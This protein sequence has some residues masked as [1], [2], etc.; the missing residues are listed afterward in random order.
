MQQYPTSLCH[1]LHHNVRY[2]TFAMT[3]DQLNSLLKDQLKTELTK[4]CGSSAWVNKM[5]EA[6]PVKDIEELLSLAEQKWKECSE[7]DWVEAFEHHPKI[8]DINSLKEKFASTAKWAQGEQAGMQQTSQ[9][10][11]ELLAKSNEAYEAKFGYIFI[12]CATGKSADEMLSILQT[13]M[14]N[15]PEEEIKI[16][17][18]EQS[19]ITAIRLRKLLLV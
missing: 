9:A 14:P 18:A 11:T 13:R 12:V 7:A 8:G 6:F 16:A 4:C 2:F 5:I 1:S 17:A 10:I 15:H 3:L 19:K